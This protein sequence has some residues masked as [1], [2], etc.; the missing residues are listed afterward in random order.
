[1]IVLFPIQNIQ[2][3]PDEGHYSFRY[4][5]ICSDRNRK[6]YSQK[7]RSEDKIYNVGKQT[8]GLTGFEQASR[9]I[10]SITRQRQYDHDHCAPTFSQIELWAYSR[11]ELIFRKPHNEYFLTYEII[12]RIYKQAVNFIFF[13]ININYSI[14]KHKTKYKKRPGGLLPIKTTCDKLLYF[15]DYDSLRDVRQKNTLKKK[16]QNS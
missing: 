3:I 2:N 13:F 1:V 8:K 6:S 16:R 12:T 9:T 4:K 5:S 11:F 10:Q 15:S 7:C 14:T